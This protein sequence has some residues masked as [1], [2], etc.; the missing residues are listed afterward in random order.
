[1]VALGEGNIR[2]GEGGEIS[3]ETI[4]RGKGNKGE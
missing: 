4:L 2:K 3:V 1:L